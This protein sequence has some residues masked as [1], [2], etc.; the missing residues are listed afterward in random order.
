MGTLT[1]GN[2][3][4]TITSMAYADNIA[5]KDVYKGMS[6]LCSLSCSVT[7]KKENYNFEKTMETQD[8]FMK[9]A[10]SEF[11]NK[12]RCLTSDQVLRLN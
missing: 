5:G 2:H 4:A 11:D 8:N 9:I 3:T 12:C 7:G 1:I 10:I 6:G